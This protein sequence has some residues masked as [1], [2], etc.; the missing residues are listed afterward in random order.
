LQPLLTRKLAERWATAAGETEAGMRMAALK[1]AARELPPANAAALGRLFCLLARAAR[2]SKHSGMTA[3]RLAAV[4]GPA[5]LRPA[6]P[7]LP[8]LA[9]E[10]AAVAAAVVFQL[11]CSHADIFEETA[12]EEPKREEVKKVEPK[13]EEVKKE[14]V[15]R[16][17]PK[18]AEPKKEEPKKEEPKKEELKK[19]AISVSAPI[20][21]AAAA[22]APAAAAPA[23]LRTAVAK[24]VAS[25]E[26]LQRG[27]APAGTAAPAPSLP[28]KKKLPAAGKV[29]AAPPKRALPSGTAPTPGAG[30]GL[31]P[32]ETAKPKGVSPRKPSPRK[33]PPPERRAATAPAAP[34]GGEEDSGTFSES[35]SEDSAGG[36]AEEDTGLRHA[37]STQDVEDMQS[38]GILGMMLSEEKRVGIS[39]QIDRK[40]NAW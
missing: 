17:E 32:G 5:L 9:Q 15:K 18:K 1:V 25:G 23:A 40:S 22:P 36:I 12:K 2:A 8:E 10:E 26:P 30:G 37:T 13:K 21:R 16:E 28:P 7:P 38:L 19:P 3:A 6:A 31:K 11:I 14:E 35:D 39:P 34:A 27:S 33:S 24:T 4:W 20:V 29:G